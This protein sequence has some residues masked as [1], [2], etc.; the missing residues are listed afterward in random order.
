M[1]C[2]SLVPRAS[3][4]TGRFNAENDWV[5]SCVIIIGRQREKRGRPYAS[6]WVRHIAR[7]RAAH[8]PKQKYDS[9]QCGY[10]P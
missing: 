10:G 8:R 1:S 7:A 4:A 9:K 3:V 2:Y 6:Q 5:D